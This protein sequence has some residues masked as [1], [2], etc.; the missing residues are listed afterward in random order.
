MKRFDVRKNDGDIHGPLLFVAQGS[1]NKNVD[2]GKL[3]YKEK[4]W[5]E[6]F[7]NHCTRRSGKDPRLWQNISLSCQKLLALPAFMK[8]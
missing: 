7:K 4:G 5:Q 3:T 1:N 2:M 8:P 6:K